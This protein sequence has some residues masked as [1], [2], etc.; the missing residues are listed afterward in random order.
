[1]PL[2]Q[3]Q[4]TTC[5]ADSTNWR[6][7]AVIGSGSAWQNQGVGIG[8]PLTVNCSTNLTCSFG[9]NTVTLIATNTAAT[10]WSSITAATNANAGTF[11]ATGNT[12]NFSGATSFI[13]PVGAGFAP[14]VNGAH[15][16]NSTN[17][18]PVFGSNGSTLTWPQNNAGSANSFVTAYNWLTGVFSV[19]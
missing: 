8:T 1:F 7:D 10:A 2:S 9:A 5:C 6:C 17:N 15:G 12:W 14:T 3:Y 16:Y 19:A 18:S 4:Y 11:A 13:A